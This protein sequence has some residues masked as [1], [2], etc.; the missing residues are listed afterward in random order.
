MNGNQFILSK[1][2]VAVAAIVSHEAETQSDQIEVASKTQGQY[3]EYMAGRRHWS[4]SANWLMVASDMMLG[5]L[6]NGQTFEISSYDRTNSRRNVHGMAKMERCSIQMTHG[7]LVR[8]QF[9]LRGNGYLFT[10]MSHGDFNFDFN[11]DFLI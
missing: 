8:G 1:D 11:D 2:G 5:L 7:T 10:Q 9:L 6:Q 3:R 4:I